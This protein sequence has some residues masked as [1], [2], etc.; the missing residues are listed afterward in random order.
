MPNSAFR[1]LLVKFFFILLEL[2]LQLI[3]K[4]E[5]IQTSSSRPI[6]IKLLFTFCYLVFAVQHSTDQTVLHLEVFTRAGNFECIYQVLRGPRIIQ[7]WITIHLQ[8]FIRSN[9]VR[10]L[11]LPYLNL[12]AML[13]ELNVVFVHLQMGDWIKFRYFVYVFRFCVWFHIV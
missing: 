5:I 4:F 3:F 6:H 8:V 1:L 2:K 10:V 12:P 13:Y 9:A 11:P 7:S